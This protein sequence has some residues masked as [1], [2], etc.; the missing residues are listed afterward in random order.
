[1]RLTFRLTPIT[2]ITEDIKERKKQSIDVIFDEIQKLVSG[3]PLP[4]KKL[5]AMGH[6][7]SR[8]NPA[9]LSPLVHVRT[10]RLRSSIR[11]TDSG[12]VF[13]NKKA[14]HLEYVVKGTRRMIP[15]DFVKAALENA[16]PELKKIWSK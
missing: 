1:M 9:I 10:G 6:P 5:R 4:N 7:F 13:E 16:L 11:K 12:I 15:R 14:P 8:R 3:D 2:K